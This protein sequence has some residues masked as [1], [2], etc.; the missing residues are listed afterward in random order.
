V[1]GPIEVV[2]FASLLLS[3]IWGWRGAFSGGRATVI[4]AGLGFILVSNF[5]IHRDAPSALGL[6]WDNLKPSL[7]EVA[8][9]TLALALTLVGTGWTL[10]TLRPVKSETLSSL[11]WLVGW[12][13]LQQ[14]ALHAFV[15]TRLCGT[16][17]R[18]VAA[19]AVAAAIFALHHLPN[20]LLTV[21]T[22]LAGLVWCSLFQ[23]QPNLF[24]LTVSHLALSLALSH[25]L[26]PEWTG[27]MRVGPGYFDFREK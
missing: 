24:T 10:G 13:F 11:P 19:A 3:Y 12:G 9:V 23:R 14:Y 6:R 22:L 20:P 4:G 7:R 5:L 16:F 26:P 8:P 21:A 27:G 1:Q 2:L 15:L 17:G 18:P 25:S